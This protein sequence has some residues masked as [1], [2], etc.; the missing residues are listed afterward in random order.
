[1]DMTISNLLT[2]DFKNQPYWWDRAP[3]VPV[4]CEGVP[5]SADVAIVGSGFTALSAALTLLR[6][7]RKVVIFDSEDPGFGASRRNAGYL[8]RTLKKSF[9][10]L[11]EAHGRESALAVYRELDA[12]LQATRALISDEA[13]DCCIARRGRFVGAT[14]VTHYDRMAKE[15][16]IT[17]RYVGFDFHMVPKSEQRGEIAS[18]RYEGGAVI[19]DLGSLHPGLYH[20]G[21]LERV[22]GA[23]GAVCGRTEVRS[24]ERDGRLFRLRTNAA[25]VMAREVIVA[26]NGYTPR[27]F[28]WHARRVIPFTAYMAATEVLGEERVGHLIPHGRT[29]LDSNMN[30]DY[31]RPAPDTPRLLFGGATGSRLGSVEAMAS[32]LGA[33]ISRI[34]PDLAGVRLSHLWTGRCAA[35]FDMMPHMGCHDGIWYGMGY[36]FAGVPMGTYFGRKI[37]QQILGLP[38]GRTVF[39]GSHFPTVP[40][41]RGNPWFVPYA[42]RYFDWRDRRGARGRRRASS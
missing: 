12:A 30:I 41:Y 34:L 27:G 2:E 7:G 18:D 8:G 23:G 16:G 37:A 33:I 19:P 26:T 15:L 38:E 40:L 21:L 10:E 39:D 14:S 32:R 11:M 24:V 3:P 1:M 28:G 35:T 4:A 9:P 36:N 22:L 13:I 25:A 17:K 5:G 20:L 31:V 42:M 6:A 29:V